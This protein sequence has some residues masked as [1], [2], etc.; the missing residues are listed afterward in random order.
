MVEAHLTEKRATSRLDD[1]EVDCSMAIELEDR[2][3]ALDVPLDALHL[4]RLVIKN[5]TDEIA[6]LRRENSRLK[7]HL[8]QQNPP[9]DLDAGSIKLEPN[10][11]AVDST[12]GKKVAAINSA[13]ERKAL[14]SVLVSTGGKE[15]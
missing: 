9:D 7:E 5:F 15:Q 2:L 11:S 10:F 8:R 4:A 14:C 3:V 1:I 13:P 6:E 12:E